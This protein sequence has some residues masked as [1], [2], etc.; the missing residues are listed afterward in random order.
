MKKKVVTEIFLSITRLIFAKI[1]EFYFH[2][3]IYFFLET[4]VNLGLV[5]LGVSSKTSV[6]ALINLF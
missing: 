5:R 2:C 1:A 4:S 6:S 3:F